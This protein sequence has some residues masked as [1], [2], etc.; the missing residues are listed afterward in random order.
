MRISDWSSTCALPICE[1]V[2][3]GFEI[4]PGDWRRATHKCADAIYSRLS[5]EAPFFDSRFAYIAESGPKGNRVKQLAIMDSDGG[6]HKFITNGQALALSP[7][8]P[9]DYK[10]IVYVRYLNN[11]VRLFLYDFSKTGRQSCRERGVPYG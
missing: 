2:R 11:R 7:P 10:K 3:Q 5:G 1:L 6:N 4:Q 8:F 9:P